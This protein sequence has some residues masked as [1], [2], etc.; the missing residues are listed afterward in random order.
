MIEIEQRGPWTDA[1]LVLLIGPGGA[2]KSSL[3]LELAPHLGRRLI[4]LDTEFERRIGGIGAFIRREGYPDYKLRNAALAAELAAECP[5]P[6]V[7]VTSSG[8][9]TPDNPEAALAANRA[10]LAA[11]SS[12][13]LLPSRDVEQAARIIVARQ[14]QRPFARGP[15]REEEVIRARHPVYAALGDL[16][17]FSAA[18]PGEIA[19][20]I[21]AHLSAT[22]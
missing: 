7:L 17:V 6:A 4:D 22:S 9:L 1:R 10:L 5:A 20:A 12:L 2:G 11:G 13:C 21:A 14:M 18:S 16:V 15:A 3:G 8:F 19:R